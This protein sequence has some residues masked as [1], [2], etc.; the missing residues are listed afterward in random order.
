L[1]IGTYDR[2]VTKPLAGIK[3]L[4]FSEHGFVPSAAA[5]LADFGADVIKI[6]RPSGD[7]MRGIISRGLVASRNGYDYLFEFCNRNKRGI[8][9]DV[10]TEGGREVF[11]RLVRWAEVYV[12]NQLP[13]V[14][15]KLRT[16]PADLFALNPKL[17][18][19]K[20]HGQ[21]QRGEDA[22]AGGYDGVSYWARG[23]VAHVLTAADA[24]H[25]VQQRPALGDFPTGMFLAGGICA[26]LVHVLRTGKG[27]VV[28]SSLLGSASWALAPDLAYASLTGEQM[29]TPPMETMSPLMR[30]YRTADGYWVALMMIDEG[31]GW[32]P[33]C[34]ALGIDGFDVHGADAESRK[35]VWPQLVECISSAVGALDRGTLTEKLRAHDCIFSFFASPTDV[36]ADAAAVENGYLM[37]HP[38]QPDLRLAAAPVQFD[39]ELPEVRRGG[40][41]RG[42][43]SREILAELGYGDSDVAELFDDGVV[44]G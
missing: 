20:G 9:L 22:E 44:S 19:A 8:C 4:D 37:P 29:P 23:G 31:R 1:R 12:T 38:T 7:P 3:V 36:L 35:A 28:D 32:G 10:E 27:I 30:Q 5:A 43:H 33:L 6:E 26:G 40:P 14:R 16:E 18:F 34:T 15:R 25:P 41:A 39:D 21:G 2:R 42:E 24:P 13:R 17:V 11:E